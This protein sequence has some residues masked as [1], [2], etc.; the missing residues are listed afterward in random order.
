MS[1]RRR[2]VFKAPV[3]SGLGIKVNG[4]YGPGTKKGGVQGANL[5]L[6]LKQQMKDIKDGEQARLANLNSTSVASIVCSL[7]LD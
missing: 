2:S 6:T 5:T 4:S 7:S 1:H 3:S